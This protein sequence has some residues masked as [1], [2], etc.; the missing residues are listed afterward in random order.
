MAKLNIEIADTPGSLA[1]GLMHRQTLS[2][3][4]GMLFKFPGPT[5]ARF[6]GKNTYIPLDVAFVQGNTITD[7]KHIAPMSTR[8]VGGRGYSTMAI[9]VNA[10]YFDEHG[11]KEGHEVEVS[12]KI[13]EFKSS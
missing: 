8:M 13:V 3:D 10:G 5:E 11:I 2:A 7:I 4:S 6:W 12:D 9:E 1:Q